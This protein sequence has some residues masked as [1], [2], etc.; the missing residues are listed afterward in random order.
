MIFMDKQGHLIS[1]H[2]IE[3][4]HAFA[5]KIGLKKEWFQDKRNKDFYYPHYDLTTPNKRV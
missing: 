3:E 2:D 5:R 1:D 4:L